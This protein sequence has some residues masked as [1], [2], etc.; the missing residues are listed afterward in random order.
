M[1]TGAKVWGKPVSLYPSLMIT[2]I[3][4][5]AKEIWNNDGEGGYADGIRKDHRYYRRPHKYW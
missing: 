2:H 3:T 1:T 4:L 5:S